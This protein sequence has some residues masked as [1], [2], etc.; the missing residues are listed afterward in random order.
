MAEL[1]KIAKLAGQ[2]KATRCGKTIQS[3]TLLQEKCANIPPRRISRTGR[4]R[5]D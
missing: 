2:M 4:R 3:V 1:P 5:Q